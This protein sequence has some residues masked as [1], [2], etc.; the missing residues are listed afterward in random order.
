MRPMLVDA[1]AASN[2][3]ERVSNRY[4][5]RMLNIGILCQQQDKTAMYN[6]R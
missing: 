3:A 6:G 1:Q 2:K 4:F 5:L